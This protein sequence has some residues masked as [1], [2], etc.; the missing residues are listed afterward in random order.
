MNQLYDSLEPN[1]Q[2]VLISTVSMHNEEFNK[3]LITR[4]Y[5]IPSVSFPA[6]FR[7]SSNSESQKA[8]ELSLYL[9]LDIHVSHHHTYTGHSI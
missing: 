1:T 3:Q 4:A 9:A 7:D 5:S 2:A 8:P 6:D